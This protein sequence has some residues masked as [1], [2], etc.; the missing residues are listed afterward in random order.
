M[1]KIIILNNMAQVFA[2]QG[3]IPKAIAFYE[4]SLEIIVGLQSG[5]MRSR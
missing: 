1:S 2:Q 5:E 3:D 4:Q